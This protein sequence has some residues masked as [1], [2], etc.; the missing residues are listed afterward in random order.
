MATASVR[1]YT[2]FQ[3]WNN[4]AAC[5]AAPW[6]VFIWCRTQRQILANDPRYFSG[7]TRAESRT[8][9]AASSTAISAKPS[10]HR[11]HAH[12][13][14]L[15]QIRVFGISSGHFEGTDDYVVSFAADDYKNLAGE[16]LASF[17]T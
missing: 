11:A 17:S 1:D 5:Y 3:I 14:H 7:T 2:P 16:R 10:K 8:P 13:E 12:G 4:P 9:A 6:N 15:S